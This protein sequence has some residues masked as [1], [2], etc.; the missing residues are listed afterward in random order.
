M[1]RIS[2][3]APGPEGIAV[4]K[5]DPSMFNAIQTAYRQVKASGIYHQLILKWGLANEELTAI[6][7]RTAGSAGG[8]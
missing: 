4:R 7:N 3:F 2:I 8:V 5:N 1:R 6:I